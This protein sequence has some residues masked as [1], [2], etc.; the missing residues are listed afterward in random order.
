MT[1][2][3]LH[4]DVFWHLVFFL[5]SDF[6]CL[7]TH[8]SSVFTWS[9]THFEGQASSNNK[10]QLTF[11]PSVEMTAGITAACLPTLKPLFTTISTFFT[12]LTSRRQ[13]PDPSK[14]EHVIDSRP[15]SPYAMSYST[16]TFLSLPRPKPTRFHDHTSDLDFD[17]YNMPTQR[18]RT[19]SRNPSNLTMFSNFTIPTALGEGDGIMRPRTCSKGLVELGEDMR[20]FKSG[21]AVSV[22]SGSGETCEGSVESKTVK[23]VGSEEDVTSGGDR[24]HGVAVVG[25]I[26]KTMEVKVT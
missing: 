19:H 16:P 18:S 4:M 3:P 17:L 20:G 26:T 13:S 7:S 23:R 12:D 9:H 10:N 15:S 1:I 5:S 25:G 22:T 2:V 24:E 11:R 14:H 8:L 21:Y 6:D